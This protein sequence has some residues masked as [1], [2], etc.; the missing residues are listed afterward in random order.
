MRIVG[1]DPG[2]QP[3]LAFKDTDNA[4]IELFDDTA[5]KIKR[6]KKEFT[7]PDVPV[8]AERLRTWR[9]DI[10][11]LEH[12]QAISGQGLTSTAS[13]MRAFGLLEGILIGLGLSYE[14]VRPQRWQRDLRVKAGPDAARAKALQFYPSLTDQL[15]RKK[16]HNRAAALLI[17]LWAERTLLREHPLFSE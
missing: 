7:E 6:G 17:M 11:A 16:D 15:S 8:V 3:A 10:V 13:F 2:V 9:P 4:R 1:I 14:L 12:V 5:R